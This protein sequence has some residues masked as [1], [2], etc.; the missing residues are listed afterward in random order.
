[1][2]I[3]SLHVWC[4]LQTVA[5]LA[6]LNARTLQLLTWL[7][8]A[9]RIDAIP[10]DPRP[11]TADGQGA[12]P[13]DDDSDTLYAMTLSRATAPPPPPPQPQRAATQQLPPPQAPGAARIEGGFRASLLQGALER[14]QG[15]GTPAQPIDLSGEGAPARSG[16]PQKP[17]V[18]FVLQL[19]LDRPH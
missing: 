2:H 5:A 3:L 12:P 17:P 7:R 18:S 8:E 15:E 16:P 9:G 13:D 19:S 14:A 1:M 11:G 6:V 10:F 4:G